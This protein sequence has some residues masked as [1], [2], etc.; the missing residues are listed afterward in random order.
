VTS[1]HPD[2]RF[3]AYVQTLGADN[4]IIDKLTVGAYTENRKTLSNNGATPTMY[5]T[6]STYK[7]GKFFPRGSRGYINTIEVYCDNSDS[8]DHTFSIYVS[9]QPGIGRTL[10]LT[11]T[12]PAGSNPAWRGVT[13]GSFW[14]YDSMFIYLVADNATYPRIGYDSGTPYDWHQS[15]DEITWTPSNTRLWI[16]ANMT[17]ETVG[18]VPVSGTVNAISIPSVATAP[19]IALYLTANP[20]AQSLV[21]VNGS[22]KLTFIA[23]LA[24]DNGARDNLEPVIYVDGQ[25]VFPYGTKTFAQL[26]TYH[27]SSGVSCPAVSWS[28]WDTT[29]QSYVLQVK[30]EFPF[31]RELK[32]GI[33]NIDPSNA[34]SA[35]LYTLVEK[36]A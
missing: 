16:R 28:K 2:F 6:G 30:L 8:A 23:W 35:E 3:S 25:Q 9:P 20:S 4:L 33:Y 15:T 11:L 32:V 19:A 10:S 26:Q 18:D 14:N 13:V 21:T 36:V 34:H 12:V 27:I 1:G 29:G 5:A 24:V 31:R 22:G 7:R 17:A